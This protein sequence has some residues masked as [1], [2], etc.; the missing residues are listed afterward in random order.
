MKA[1]PGYGVDISEATSFEALGEFIR[2][3][4]ELYA[5][6]LN[7]VP[8]IL[9]ERR[10][11]LDSKRNPFFEHT[12]VAFFLAHR[13]GRLVGRIAAGV[14]ERYN[15]FHKTNAGFVG[16]FECIQDVGVAAGLFEKAGVW[17]KAH[18]AA[19]VLGP[20][21]MAFHHECGLLV[22][23]FEHPHSMFTPYNPPYY[24][25]LFEANHFQKA[26]D[27]FSYAFCAQQEFPPKMY[28]AAQRARQKAGLHL[29]R[30]NVE[31]LEAEKDSIKSIYDSMRKPGFGLLPLT[32][33]E[34]DYAMHRLKPLI[35]ARPELCWMVEAEGEPV[36]FSLSMPDAQIALRSAG[37]YL[38]RFGIPW[39]LLKIFWAVHRL[40]RVRVFL[41][42][43]RPGFQR[44]G[45]DALLAQETVEAAR[46]LGYQTGELGWIAEDDALLGRTVQLLGAKQIKTFRVYRRPL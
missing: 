14:D 27:L 7:F 40:K 4:L 45:L 21:S 1:P 17:L 32:Q 31:R 39:G 20:L 29:R 38:S 11:F 26:K 37:G 35:F 16:L 36:A 22:K 44:L 5:G 24:E 18:G 46:N 43:I 10:E 6:D 23:G 28:K 15:R 3:P 12:R 8:P 19:E 13:E 33:A 42:G 9:V 34:F 2:F 30:L 25:A 41:F